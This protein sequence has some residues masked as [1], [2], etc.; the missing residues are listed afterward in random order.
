MKKGISILF[1]VLLFTVSAFGQDAYKEERS[2]TGFNKVAFAVA[3][4]VYITIGESFKVTIEGDK[5]Y[6]SEIETKVSGGELVIKTEK[7]F[8]TGSKKVIVDITM[9]S[10]TGVD[11][12]GSGKVV[13][14][15]ALKGDDFEVNI[16]GSGKVNLIDVQLKWVECDISGSGS[17]LIEGEGS[18]GKLEIAISGSGSYKGSS[19]KVGTFDAAISGSGS[20]DCFVTDMLKA[21]I[22]GSGNIY[23]SGNPKIDA[24]ISGS[25]H[26]R[27]K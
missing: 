17:L 13:V 14:N 7:W 2:V 8:N 3:G 18:V 23:Y 27:T 9:P 6:I 20:C 24:A 25:G 21:A 1:A 5:D 10:L 19:T 15:N 26:V 22:S 16:S 11:V 4:E 12:S